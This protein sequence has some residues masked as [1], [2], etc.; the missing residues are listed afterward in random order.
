MSRVIDTFS[1]RI[2]GPSVPVLDIDE[3]KKY[4]RFAPTSEDTLIDIW[5]E[6][7]TDYFESQ[8]GIICINQTWELGLNGTPVDSEIELPKAPL[9][10]VESIVSGEDAFASES[11]EVVTATVGATR[12]GRVRL[13]SG[14]WPTVVDPNTGAIRIQ[15]VAGFGAQPGSVPKLIV[16]AIGMLLAHFHK[17]R[18]PV[19]EQTAG[20]IVQVPLGAEA[21]IRDYKYSNVSTLPPRGY[22]PWV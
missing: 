17:F 10:S 13:L 14:T 15:Y 3:A 19:H 6:A 11:Y 2:T 8:T 20:S 7:A 12:R 18:A 9:Q 4:L 16:A 21:I 22:T 5:I 1:R